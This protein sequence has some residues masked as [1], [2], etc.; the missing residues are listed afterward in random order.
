M[1]IPELKKTI[2]QEAIDRYARAS[3]DFNP[4]HIDAAFARQ[5]PAGGT[6]AHGMLILAYVSRVMTEAYGKAWLA[7]GRLDVRFKNPARP[8]DTITVTGRV[9][10]E[11]AEGG[12]TVTVCEIICHNQRGE[13]IITGDATV[14]LRH[15]GRL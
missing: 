3:G 12:S 10:R 14:I 9:R 7:G 15:D 1:T 8:G 5:T 2:T 13:P 6:I 11:P 4:I